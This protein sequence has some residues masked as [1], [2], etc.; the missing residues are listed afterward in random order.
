MCLESS[1]PDIV[2]LRI[3]NTEALQA[4]GVKVKVEVKAKAVGVKAKAVGATEAA[5]LA[6]AAREEALAAAARCSHQG[7]PRGPLRGCRCH[8]HSTHP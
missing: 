7:S 3:T 6:E 5:D 1:R 4:V 2:L 8:L